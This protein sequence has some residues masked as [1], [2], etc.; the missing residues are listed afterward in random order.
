MSSDTVGMLDTGCWSA[1]PLHSPCPDKQ[2]LPGPSTVTSNHVY[3]LV[4][5]LTSF[6]FY[7]MTDP[8]VTDLPK[9]HQIELM[10]TGRGR[11][12]MWPTARGYHLGSWE[13][14]VSEENRWKRELRPQSQP[15]SATVSDLKQLSCFGMLTKGSS[16]QKVSLT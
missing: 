16:G 3:R 9:A 14:L 2:A 11:Y 12:R 13:W 4:L 5:R 15:S 6:S 8:G 1:L 10:H 7:S